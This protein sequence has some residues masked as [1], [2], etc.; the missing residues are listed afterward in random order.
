MSS[1]ASLVTG[2]PLAIPSGTLVNEI[3]ACQ[4]LR[5]MYV[6]PTIVEQVMQEP[7]GFDRLRQLDFLIYTGGP[8]SASVGDRLSKEL[9]LCSYYGATEFFQIHTYVPHPEDWSYMEWIPT[10]KADMQPSIDGAYELVLHNDPDVAK[11]RPLYYNFPDFMDWHTKDLFKPHPTKPNLWRYH[12]RAD[13]IIVFSNGAKF[14]PVAAEAII[15]AH[16]SVAGAI[17][18][19]TARSQAALVIEP[20]PALDPNTLENLI[21]EIWPVV[22]KANIQSPSQGRVIR[23]MIAVISPGKP[24]PRAAKGTVVR[25]SVATAFASEI[26]GLYAAVEG[27]STL[28]P[29]GDSVLEDT[30]IKVCVRHSVLNVLGGLEI[31]DN[32]D[33]FTKGLDSVKTVE[34]IT[35]IR[36]TFGNGVATLSPRMVYTN[37]TIAKLSAAIFKA[38][39][40][41]NE[42]D[43][44]AVH[45]ADIDTIVEEYSKS[46][47]RKAPRI[48]NSPSPPSINVALT[49]STG[50]LGGYLLQSLIK[51][52]EVAAVYCLDR[53]A[54]ASEKHNKSFFG[55]GLSPRQTAKITFIQ[56]DFGLNQLGLPTRLYAELSDKVDFILHNAWNVNFNMD[57]SSFAPTHIHGVR[58]L[59]DWSIGSERNPHIVFLSSISSVSNWLLNHADPVPERHI[60]DV[61][62]VPEMGYAQSKYVAEKVLSIASE[63]CGV[64]FSVLRIGQI[65]GPVTTTGVWPETEWFPALLK[66]SESLGLIPNSLPPVDWIQID[67]LSSVI[68]E[69]VHHAQSSGE[70]GFYNVINP[71]PSSWPSLINTVAK[72]L[73]PSPTKVPMREW[74]DALK[75]TKATSKKEIVA[76]PAL[77]IID[78]FEGLASKESESVELVYETERARTAS[79]TMAELGPVSQQW[80]EIWLNQIH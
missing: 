44:V 47:P 12:G 43:P 40:S 25:H 24:F 11:H 22:E 31:T 60:D 37:C 1:R 33:L 10:V 29:V 62:A 38:L 19:G 80:M 32:D 52:P 56:V 34:L 20:K 79:K 26:D 39:K 21:E 77:K 63:R 51:A 53:S 69:M 73:K 15:Q 75:H 50:L 48:T 46:L 28:D 13:D 54:D 3:M 76:R 41:R 35:L 66:T 14:S 71:H 17:I 18:L 27:P 16:P 64:P 78:F 30:A 45:R 42:N 72:H 61:S 58:S 2:P 8:L 7:E 49:G 57:L 74:C 67:I 68:V 65:A 9:D 23:S 4:E 5:A 70:T 55:F 59:I 36:S 6:P